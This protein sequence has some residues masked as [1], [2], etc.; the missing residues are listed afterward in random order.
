MVCFLLLGSLHAQYSIV[1]DTARTHH[2]QQMYSFERKQEFDRSKS[3]ALHYCKD[4]SGTIDYPFMHGLIVSCSNLRQIDTSFLLMHQLIYCG[5]VGVS[6]RMNM[7]FQ[8]GPLLEYKDSI[9]AWQNIADSLYF[10]ECALNNPAFDR[11]LAKEILTIYIADQ[12]PRMY[13]DFCNSDS[14]NHY[15]RDS[16]A[17]AWEI[18]DS[19]NEIM[20]GRIFDEYG[21]PTIQMVGFDLT[22]DI[23]FPLQHGTIAF[24][25]KYKKLARRAYKRGDLTANL[26]AALID[27]METN[28]GKKQTYGSQYE[29]NSKGEW[30]QLPIRRKCFLKHRLRKMNMA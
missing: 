27:R 23:W 22:Q 17:V 18:S 28:Q 13:D 11:E 2:L 29:E 7:D 30:I 26:Y 6:E 21:W 4:S 9:S 16:A 3:I 14:T 25:K 12:W 8:L 5:D 15:N 10:S 24:Q 19:I 1:I 20:T